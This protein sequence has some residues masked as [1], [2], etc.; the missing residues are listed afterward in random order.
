VLWR[1]GV[2]LAE[3]VAGTELRGLGVVELGAG[4]G[5]PSLAAARG[6]AEVLA[7][8]ADPEA[9]ALLERNAGANGVSVEGAV[10]DW[11][12]PGPL[13]DRAP[14]ELALAADILYLPSSADAMLELLPRLAS[15]AWIADPGRADA[16]TFLERAAEQWTVTTTRRGVVRIHRMRRR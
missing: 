15:E 6:G 5:L 16:G 8:D 4:L 7:A 2:A 1:S 11:H 14:F 12:F 13:V 3:E 9:L 10:V